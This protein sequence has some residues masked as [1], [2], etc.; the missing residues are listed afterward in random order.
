MGLGEEQAVKA[1]GRRRSF[2]NFENFQMVPRLPEVRF[3]E[4][5]LEVA[6]E[7]SAIILKLNGV[8]Q[9]LKK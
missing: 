2:Q 3:V 1:V 9:A 4:V 6:W 5:V 8:D 7:V